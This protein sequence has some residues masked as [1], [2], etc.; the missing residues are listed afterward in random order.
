MAQNQNQK[1]LWVFVGYLNINNIVL[2]NTYTNKN[3]K[4]SALLTKDDMSFFIPTKC[5]KTSKENGEVYISLPNTM[6]I[7]VRHSSYNS[8]SKKYVVTKEEEVNPWELRE[9]LGIKKSQSK[10]QPTNDSLPF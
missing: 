2:R 1:L 6:T 9:L 7:K 10:A 5:L 8:F 4:T 3:G